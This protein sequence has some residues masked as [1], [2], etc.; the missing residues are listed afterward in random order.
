M[1]NEN[2]QRTSRRTVTVGWLILLLALTLIEGLW[3]GCLWMLSRLLGCEYVTV[4]LWYNAG[5]IVF[6]L[7]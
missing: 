2:A 5:V 6:A 3:K 4:V 1:T 7:I